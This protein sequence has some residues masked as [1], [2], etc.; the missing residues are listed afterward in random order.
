M[1]PGGRDVSL[2]LTPGTKA[3]TPFPFSGMNLQSAPM[4]MADQ[5]FLYIFNYLRLGD[6]KLRTAWD[7]GSPFYQAPTGKSIVSF[8][9]YTVGTNYYCAV[10]LSDGS[11]VQ[12]DM[13]SGIATQM[14]PPGTFYV[15]G[16]SLPAAAQWGTLYLI[17][18]NRNTPNDYWIWE[19]ANTY[20]PTNGLLY[21]SGTISPGGVDLL[22]TGS[23][24]TSL[25]TLTVFGGSGS[26]VVL[27]PSIN[28]GG[29]VEVDIAN[30]GSGY[31]VGDVV[32]VQF[33]GGGAD[34]GPIL[35]AN[36]SAGGVA[37]GNIT[38]GGS[39]YTTATAAFSGG[40]GTGAA[41]TLII[42]SGVA[43]VAVTAQGSGYTNATVNFTGGG[44]SGAIAVA[45]I[46]G[47]G[48]TAIRVVVPGT[49]YT[50][51][52]TVTLTGDGTG[53]TATA[54]IVNGAI[55]GITITNPG[56][57]YVTAPTITITG[58]GTG[59]SATAVLGRAGV[60][61]VTVGDGG[62][63]FTSAPLIEF[64][65]G[66][67]SGATG[68]AYLTPTSI[69]RVNLTAPGQGYQAP[70]TI[71]FTGSDG[72]GATATAVIGSG[73]QIVAINLTNAGSGYDTNVEVVITPAAGDP[74][75]G[76]GA[77][78][79]FAPTSIASVIISSTGSDYTTAPA[80]E[81]EPGANNAAY[82]TITLMPFGISGDALET[83]QS[84]V[85]I[86]NPAPA[87]IGDLPPGGNFAVSAPESLTDF[88]TSDGG[89]LFTNSDG[90]LQTR[91][92]GIRQSAGYL[93]FF[94]DGSVSVVSNVQTSGTP[95]V[96]S[97]NYQN[98]DPQAGL[99][100]RDSRVD[101]GRSLLIANETGIFGLYGG[102]VT[103]VS[104][105]LNDLF[106]TALFP[107]TSGA[108][109]PSGAVAT[110]FDVKHY[111]LLMTVTDPV[112]GAP[113]NVMATWNEKEWVLTSQTPNLIY[114]G[115]QKVESKFQAWGTDGLGLYPLFSQP[116]VSL[117]KQLK[118]KVY[119]G[120]PTG[121]IIK[122]LMGFYLQ[123]QDQ[124]AGQTGVSTTVDFAVSGVAIQ[125]PTFSSV[126]SGAYENVLLQQPNFQAPRPYWP[127]YGV[128]LEGLPFIGISATLTTQ[129]ADF[130][131]GNLLMTY[132]DTIA[133]V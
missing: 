62:T 77:V 32:Q 9:F 43:S 50:S 122:D 112:T 130:V 118:T 14:G 45:Q 56:A 133:V 25:P 132:V 124:T 101:F 24:Y 89:L 41:G 104:D 30:P 52:P 57:N 93:Y 128:G 1:P 113:S 35:I 5:E 70:P 3:Y 123:T 107:T 79:V 63:G 47:G 125:N 26:G 86:A 60:A 34:N 106:D 87:L 98:V 23:N 28:A 114:I 103:K 74:G 67:G 61:S 99:S 31:E 82:A 73:G 8:F 48:V 27:V 4:A 55:V 119:G 111:L 40:G 66:G 15:S 68:V 37:A 81:V 10:F 83:F 64:V 127:L 69:A 100:W 121:F 46:I 116:S 110:L 2:G 42:G 108:L 88:A 76:G 58:D 109:T 80:V 84:R 90:F 85:W 54:T 38:A 95:P 65:G 18:S 75:T 94:G 71:T 49:G 6:G 53:A 117:T 120:G 19:P 78:A 36:L 97:F 105:K 13:F 16:G 39:G 17:I 21:G 7:A 33:T 102:A 96:T 92:T 44:G 129:S 22:A 131:L 59:A 72:T 20:H 11:G 51:A 29:V 126:P 115:A 91:Y 12:V